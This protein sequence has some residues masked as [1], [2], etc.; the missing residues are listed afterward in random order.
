M[1]SDWDTFLA[2]L[3]RRVRNALEWERKNITDG[4]EYSEYEILQIFDGLVMRRKNSNLSRDNVKVQSFDHSFD[5]DANVIEPGVFWCSLYQA[6]YRICSA[7]STISLE[8]F[9]LELSIDASRWDPIVGYMALLQ[10][11]LGHGQ[12]FDLTTIMIACFDNEARAALQHISM[13]RGIE[14]LRLVYTI[15][16]AA[17]NPPVRFGWLADEVA[18]ILWSTP[19]ANGATSDDE[20]I[21][22]AY[23]DA[24]RKV[25]ARLEEQE[26]NLRALAAEVRQRIRRFQAVMERPW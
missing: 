1:A 7:G 9:G 26:R 4:P 15:P 11:G 12:S 16:F 20:P 23:K 14:L 8:E 21:L 18:R 5:L 17:R 25:F 22:P 10:F 3:D 6:A 19:Q 2:L 13:C 24:A